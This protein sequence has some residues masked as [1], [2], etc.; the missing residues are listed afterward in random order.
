MSDTLARPEQAGGQGPSAGLR[1]D[2]P[3][4]LRYDPRQSA[5][6][7]IT[8][9]QQAQSLVVIFGPSKGGPHDDVLWSV[10]RSEVAPEPLPDVRL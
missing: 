9:D 5:D 7:V 8:Y 2:K 1:F 3:I 6:T 10:L 4:L